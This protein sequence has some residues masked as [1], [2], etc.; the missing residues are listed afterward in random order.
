MNDD[1]IVDIP[2]KAI[3]RLYDEL[4]DVVGTRSIDKENVV[5][6]VLSLMK[7]VE[8]HDDVKGEQKKNLII[9]VLNCFINDT[10]SDKNEAE[11]IT[12]IVNFTL[13]T[14]ID[15]I[16]SIDKK[17][18]KIKLVKGCNKLFACCD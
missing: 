8:K 12:G 2:T 15:T 3:T 9:Y 1:I 13:P 16:V 10:V 6:I 7:L 18:L 14:V 17:E 4:K 11:V 5:G